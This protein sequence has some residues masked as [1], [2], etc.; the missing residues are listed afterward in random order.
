VGTVEP[1]PWDLGATRVVDSS[2]H[3]SEGY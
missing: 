2:D 1:A 3:S